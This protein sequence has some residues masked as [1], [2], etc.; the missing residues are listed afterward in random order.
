MTQHQQVW[1]F[2]GGGLGGIAWETGMLTGFADE[3]VTIARDATIIG[4]SA[5]ATVAAQVASGTPLADLYAGQLAG[6]PYEISKSFGLGMLLKFF[7]AQLFAH[8]AEQAG[9][10]L[11][12]AALDAKVGTVEERR[13]VIEARLPRHDWSSADLW[14][15]VVDAVSGE[16]R[17]IRR[18]DGFDLV[19]VVAA[20][21]S[22]PMVWPPVTLGT[23][24]Y[25]DGGVRSAL[26]LD[27]APGTGPVVALAPAPG[28]IGRWA[29]IGRQRE[30]LGAERRVLVLSMA[31]EVRIVHGPNA[32]DRSIVPAVVA[33][34]RE[35][36]RRDAAQVSALLDDQ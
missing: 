19:D 8:S 10:T 7:G 13:G 4:T 3:G 20:S 21:C 14:I 17:V 2:G 28:G 9:R 26:N 32:L 6:L 25:I 23:R 30:L 29:W 5:G 22:V 33:A 27:L 11:G 15:V 16:S 24:H 12:K 35:Q 36:G 1:V 18:S 31:P 34:A